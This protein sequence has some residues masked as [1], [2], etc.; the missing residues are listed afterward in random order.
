MIQYT[1][2]LYGFPVPEFITRRT[3]CFYVTSVKSTINKRMCFSQKLLP[4]DPLIV[5]HGLLGLE[6]HCLAAEAQWSISNVPLVCNVFFNVFFGS[7]LPYIQHGFHSVVGVVVLVFCFLH[8]ACFPE[9]CWCCCSCFLVF[10][11]FVLLFWVSF[12]TI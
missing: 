5:S 9:C 7:D 11:L 2:F 4:L 3:G 12:P 1:L 8:P 6:W 10:F